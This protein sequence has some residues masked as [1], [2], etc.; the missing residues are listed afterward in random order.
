MVKVGH[1]DG[2]ERVGEKRDNMNSYTPLYYIYIYI[3]VCEYIRVFVA[4]LLL[5]RCVCPVGHIGNE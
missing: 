1:D 2:T 5:F 4:F 3:F